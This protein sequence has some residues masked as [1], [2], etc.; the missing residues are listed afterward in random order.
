M[1]THRQTVFVLVSSLG[2]ASAAHAQVLSIVD[3]LPGEFTDISR[4][5]TP[6]NLSGNLEAQINTTIGNQ[7]F[8]AGRVIVGNNGGLGFDPFDP[9][10]APDNEPLPS[11]AAFGGAQGAL[12]FWDNINNVVG[13]VFWQ[14]IGNTLI[15]QWHNNTFQGSQ[16][17]SR[18]QIKIGEPARGPVTVFAQFIYDDIEQP[19]AGGGI[20]ATIG[21]Q[22]GGA[23]FNDVQWSFNTAGAVSNGTVLSLVPEP[24]SAALLAMGMLGLLRKR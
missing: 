16:D 15:V 3:N 12:A 8:S 19:R 4:T 5:G 1:T 20:S 21:Y 14:E 10:L 13:D 9:E 11:N 2:L 17:T 18:F 22:D 23:G 24:G 6:L 7:V